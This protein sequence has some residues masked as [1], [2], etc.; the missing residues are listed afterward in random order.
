MLL[1]IPNRFRRMPAIAHFSTLGETLVTSFFIESCGLSPAAA[2]AATSKLNS[3][4]LSRMSNACI[5][6]RGKSLIAFFQSY[7]FSPSQI[8]KIM[9]KCPRFFMSNPNLTFRPKVE[10]FLR[11]GFQLP[12]LTKIITSDPC[13]LVSSLNNRIIPSLDFLKTILPADEAVVAAVKRSTRMLHVDLKTKMA[14]KIETLQAIGVPLVNIAK[15]AKTHPSVLM[16]STARFGDSLERAVSMGFNPS[17]AKFIRALHSLSSISPA[18]FERKLDVCKSFGLAEDKVLGLF[19]KNPRILNLSEHNL[20]SSFDFFV[21]R[22]NW[23]PE[24]LLSYSVLLMLSLEKRI[25]PRNFLCGALDLKGLS[26]SLTGKSVT[27]LTFLLPEDDF[28]RQYLQWC[29]MVWPELLEDYMAMKR[30]AEAA[31]K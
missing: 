26:S 22:L 27:P 29:E 20:R 19:K 9:S 25:K 4:S 21:D 18:S 1:R 6:P 31:S 2:I 10:F 5:H 13:I 8:S 3:L 12:D 14:P 15:L 23:R 17:E 11:Y 24:V 7:C 28:I 16:Q 30:R